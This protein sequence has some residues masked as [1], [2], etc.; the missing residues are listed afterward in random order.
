M[1]THQNTFAIGGLENIGYVD[2][3]D[4]LITL[5]SQGRGIF[6]CVVGEKVF[7]DSTDW[8]KQ[9]NEIDSTIEGFHTE[10]EKLIRTCGL[11]GNNKLPT[12]TSDDFEL[13]VT[14]P[15]PDDHPLEK[16]LVR[17]IYLLSPSKQEKIYITKDG[18][19]ELRAVGFSDTGK[20]FVVAL[21]CEL[22]I[23]ARE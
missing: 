14:A 22:T 7:R 16:H 17:R 2:G 12:K 13:I 19:C 15:E 6:D 21:S 18:A 10:V 8:W 9:F 3:S 5:S 1:W 20:T 4:K 11:Y 23:W